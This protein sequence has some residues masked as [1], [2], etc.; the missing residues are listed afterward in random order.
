MSEFRGVI[1]VVT[2]IGTAAMAMVDVVVVDDVASTVG[3]AA[4]VDV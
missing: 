2:G 3:A 1:V 4:M